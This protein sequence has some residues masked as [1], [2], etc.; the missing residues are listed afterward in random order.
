MRPGDDF[1]PT[2]DEFL[3]RQTLVRD[4]DA[5]REIKRAIGE[6]QGRQ[7]QLFNKSG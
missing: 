6:R 2:V 7:K 3:Q 5:L 4:T 1:A